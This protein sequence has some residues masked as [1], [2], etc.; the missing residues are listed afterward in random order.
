[1]IS[2]TST[3]LISADRKDG[4]GDQPQLEDASERSGRF[5]P[6]T[7][8]ANG[9]AAFH[10]APLPVTPA[11]V[12]TP[13]L[14]RLLDLA[15]QELGRLDG[16]TTLLPDPQTLLYA[17][18]RKEAVLSS[19]IEGTQSSLA[20]L[21][22]FDRPLRRDHTAAS[23]DADRA[24]RPADLRRH[25]SSRRARRAPRDHRAT[26]WEAWAYGEYLDT[27]TEGTG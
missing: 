27:L 19:Q 24:H 10:P 6:I 12:L 9:Y 7:G 13:A 14:Q 11:I 26:A 15:N 4:T 5:V 20:D 25:P 23:R 21:L 16:I 17:Y 18:V 3:S 1:M 2:F 8:G 22:L